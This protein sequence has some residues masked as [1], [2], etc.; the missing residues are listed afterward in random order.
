VIGEV[1]HA[2]LVTERG[3]TD[4][5][6]EVLMHEPRRAQRDHVEAR[7]VE[8]IEAGEPPRPDEPLELAL[9]EQQAPFE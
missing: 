9:A 1:E 4:D 7:P 2:R 6:V 5:E 8:R 3:R